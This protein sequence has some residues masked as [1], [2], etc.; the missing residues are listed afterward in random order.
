[1]QKCVFHRHAMAKQHLQSDGKT[2]AGPVGIRAGAPGS[3]NINPPTRPTILEGHW[4]FI[5]RHQGV[6]DKTGITLPRYMI[7][8]GLEPGIS[9][10]EGRRLI[11]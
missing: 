5:S 2:M 3:W 9:G 4:E 6:L 1:M 10:S 8:P 7:R 11:H